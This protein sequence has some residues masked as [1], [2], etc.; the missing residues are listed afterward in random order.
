MKTLDQFL[1]ENSIQQFS[2]T[3]SYYDGGYDYSFFDAENNIMPNDKE[4]DI[5]KILSRYFDDF[6]EFICEQGDLLTSDESGYINLS[7]KKEDDWHAAWS[8]FETQEQKIDSGS[9]YDE[10]IIT[11]W[12]KELLEE[13]GL[14]SFIDQQ[15]LV[16][17]LNEKSKRYN[18]SILYEGGGDS[19]DINSVDLIEIYEPQQDNYPVLYDSQIENKL[20]HFASDIIN[21]IDPGFEVNSGGGGCFSCEINNDGIQSVSH[22]S[23]YYED[24]TTFNSA[25]FVN[26]EVLQKIMN[27]IIDDDLNTL[28]EE[29]DLNV[30]F[31][32]LEL[33]GDPIH[34]FVDNEGYHRGFDWDLLKTSQDEE[35]NDLSMA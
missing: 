35:Q 26:P 20:N 10:E 12:T 1:Q 19:G 8:L 28:L 29:D 2:T 17:L 7:F 4:N 22:D 9:N 15:L 31:E 30:L 33:C 23:Y 25:H 27:A 11:K 18:I 24:V 21:L 5:G 3:I 14:K 6:I 34:L 16:S 32:N 13:G